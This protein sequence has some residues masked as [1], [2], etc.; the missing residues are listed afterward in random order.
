M[1]LY[2]RSDYGHCS[3]VAICCREANLQ[4][5]YLLSRNDDSRYYSHAVYGFTFLLTIVPRAIVTHHPTSDVII[6]HCRN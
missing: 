2:K 1:F 3:S 4:S 5:I 6:A